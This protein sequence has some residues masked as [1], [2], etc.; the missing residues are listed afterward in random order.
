[1]RTNRS[2][3]E[4]VV[5]SRLL[6]TALK[7]EKCDNLAKWRNGHKHARLLSRVQREGPPSDRE[8]GLLEPRRIK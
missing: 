2:N 7:H 3:C 4:D 6:L 1:M 8:E 5:Y